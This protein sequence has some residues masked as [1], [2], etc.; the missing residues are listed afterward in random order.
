MNKS[1]VWN[2]EEKELFTNKYNTKT[3]ITIPMEMFN[4]IQKL[5]DE[6]MLKWNPM[7]RILL[8]DHLDFLEAQKVKK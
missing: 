8:R 6:K 4:T 5:A 1:H 3:T 7:A 2:A